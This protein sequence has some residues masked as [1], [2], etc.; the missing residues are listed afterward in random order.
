MSKFKTDLDNRDALAG[1][2]DSIVRCQKDLELSNAAVN[3]E[4][5]TTT[6]IYENV[7]PFEHKQ[8]ILSKETAD[9]LAM[10][11]QLLEEIQ[12]TLAIEFDAFD[13]EFT[14]NYEV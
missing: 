2:L 12:N 14:K 10:L 11:V 7:F 5:L 13:K 6:V 9:N 4:C 8:N 3:W 1:L